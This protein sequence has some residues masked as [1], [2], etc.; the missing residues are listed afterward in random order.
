M[1]L[2]KVKSR[3][4]GS[5]LTPFESQLISSYGWGPV[6][7]VLN[8]YRPWDAFADVTIAF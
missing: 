5:N 6:G 8:Q 3:V 2:M 7:F 4:A 1:T